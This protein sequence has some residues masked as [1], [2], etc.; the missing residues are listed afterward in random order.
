MKYFLLLILTI[1]F[2]G[3]IKCAPIEEDFNNDKGCFCLTW[4]QAN[5]GYK[6]QISPME[7]LLADDDQGRWCFC[8]TWNQNACGK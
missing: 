5:C 8:I 3:I 6:N 7:E 2:I 4:N 1:C